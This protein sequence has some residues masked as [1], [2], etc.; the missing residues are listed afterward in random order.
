M[1]S[2]TGRHTVVVGRCRG[3]GGLRHVAPPSTL[4]SLLRAE[5]GVF[6][7]DQQF[8]PIGAEDGVS[9]TNAQALGQFMEF[10]KT[11][12]ESGGRQLYL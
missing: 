9:L 7:T 2:P 12:K 6:Y 1:V 10:I 8:H 5:G 3:P 4:C 11:Y